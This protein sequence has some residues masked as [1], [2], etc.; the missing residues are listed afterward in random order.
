MVHAL[1]AR[2]DASTMPSVMKD[3][4]GRE[5]LKRGKVVRSLPLVAIFKDGFKNYTDRPC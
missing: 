5:M 1:G 3:M 2:Y 4:Q